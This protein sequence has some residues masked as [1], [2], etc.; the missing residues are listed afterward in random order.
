MKKN[1]LPFFSLVF[2]VNAAS[3]QSYKFLYHLDDNLVPVEKSRAT[4]IGKGL[5]DST[6]FLV[7]CFDKSTGKLSVSAHFAD[8][9]LSQFEGMYKTYFSSGQTKEEG[10]Y[11]NGEQQG[12]WFLWD[13]AGLKTVAVVFDKGKQLTATQYSYH[14]GK[15]NGKRVQDS[16]GVET[17]NVL[18]DKKG[19]EINDETI[20]ENVD[21]KPVFAEGKV[22]FQR[23]N[24]PYTNA[25]IPYSMGA[26]N[27]NYLVYVSFVV[28]KDGRLTDIKAVSQ[29]GYGME[30]E[31]VRVVKNSPRWQPALQNGNPVRFRMQTIVPFVVRR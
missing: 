16:N 21:I 19:N 15:L 30:N 2:F 20:F 10:N 3:A 18:Y 27:G 5:K 9:S 28:E 1:L 11:V 26:S 6:I 31:A 17:V 4:L 24:I 25:Q 7:D 23:Y 22:E 14:K 8:S 12:E 13:S 29:E